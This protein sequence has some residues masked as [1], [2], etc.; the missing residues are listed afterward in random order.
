M[1]DC[2]TPGDLVG[3]LTETL[4]GAAAESVPPHVRGCARCQARLDALSDDPELRGW[5]D[6]S[7]RSGEGRWAGRDV[8]RLIGR[9]RVTMSGRPGRDGDP[10]GRFSFL[11]PPSRDG[12]LGVIGGYAVSRELGRGGMGIVLL[13]FDEALQR[14]V[15]LKVLRPE[16]ADD[17]ARARFVR[18][19]RAAARVKHDH[20]VG[21]YGV[22]DPPDGPP[23]C[24]LEF[25]AGPSLAERIRAEGRLAPRE[26]AAIGAQVA[27][28]LAAAHAAGLVHRDVKPSNILSDSATGRS[29]IADFG[30]ARVA[31]AADGPTQI[32]VLAGTPAYMSP[33]QA[34]GSERIG[35]QTDVYGLGATLYEALT[36]E[37]PFRGAPHTVLQRVL[38]DEPRPPRELNDAVPRDLETVCLTCLRKE[39]NRRYADA[40]ALAADLRRFLRGEPV[41]ARPVRAWERWMRWARRRKA[42]A[43]LSAFSI[44]ATIALVIGGVVLSVR[45]HAASR[46]AEVRRRQA[47]ANFQKAF[48]AVNRMLSRVGGERLDDVPEMEDVRRDVLADALEFL[49]GF[50]AERGGDDPVVRRELGLAYQQMAKIHA[51][52]GSFEPARDELVQALRVQ[53]RLTA[54]FAGDPQYRRDLAAS[55]VQLGELYSEDLMEEAEAEVQYRAAL[56]ILEPLVAKVPA[57]RNDHLRAVGGA[58]ALLRRTGRVEDLR[59]YAIRF[60]AIL[61]ELSREDSA[62]Y[63]VDVARL[64]HNLGQTFNARGQ[65]VEA[66]AAYRRCLAVMEPLA[67]DRHGYRIYQTEL[68]ECFNSLGYLL[69]GQ[70]RTREAEDVLTQALAVRQRLAR[71]YPLVP[72]MREGL[73]KAHHALGVL[74]LK[75]GR[76]PDAEAAYLEANAIR[77]PAASQAR[78]GPLARLRLAEGYVNLGVVYLQ[79]GRPKQARSLYERAL[80]A[81]EALTREHPGEVM[82]SESLAAIQINL[83]N[84]LHADGQP[85][86]ALVLIDRAAAALVRDEHRTAFVSPRK[87][88]IY[89]T[90]AQVNVTLGRHAESVDD[91][92]RVIELSTGVSRERF[93]LMRCFARVRAGQFDQAA[94]EVGPLTASPGASGEMLYNSACVHALIADG[95]RAESGAIRTGLESPDQSHA[96]AAVALLERARRAGFL[97]GRAGYDQLTRDHDLDA[98]RSRPDFRAL[99]LD[100]AFPAD[101]FAR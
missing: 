26:A 89:G 25:L 29:K 15:A 51:L 47:E 43:A 12:D 37:P 42:V 80:S 68:A 100:V 58:A 77:E 86:E 96:E 11:G 94:A 50:L 64:D 75:L 5:A 19:A 27:D 3:L 67:R 44:A 72:L 6:S 85:G 63:R 69:I 61:A 9:L 24:T 49:K 54:E 74:Y 30:L 2:P 21:V 65:A 88:E 18:E 56:A 45:L 91:W 76:I 81:L 38:N 70:D 36:G 14:D 84:L 46:L 99:A 20:V 92:G 82:F 10:P 4:D 23:F 62:N 1:D 53:E 57:A 39:P 48:E 66:E 101:P 90:R 17:L 31:A 16:L 8:D 93:I 73:A 33:E 87:S 98:L 35:P 55:H 59:P 40:A 32:G 60:Q 79:S 83:A 41:A 34:R 78:G 95:A 52:L 97:E 13:G 22:V 28:G 7:E 71:R